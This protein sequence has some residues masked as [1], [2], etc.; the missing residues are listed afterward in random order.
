MSRRDKRKRNRG[1]FKASRE[2]GKETSRKLRQSE[3]R[4]NVR[5]YQSYRNKFRDERRGLL[6]ECAK[7][8]LS[9]ELSDLLQQLGFEISDFIEFTPY[10][11]DEEITGAKGAGDTTF[12]TTLFKH[13]GTPVIILPQYVAERHFGEELLHAGKLGIFFHELGHVDDFDKQL[14]FDTHA[15]RYNFVNAEGHA[16][17]FACAHLLHQ[18]CRAALGLYLNILRRPSHQ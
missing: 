17:R 1:R 14:N 15:K 13:D 16:H 10:V 7:A 2:R 6:Y 8:N 9:G 5:I 18:K 11:G 12:G 4:S 3:G